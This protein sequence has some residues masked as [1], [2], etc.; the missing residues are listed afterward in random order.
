[1]LQFTLLDFSAGHPVFR[2]GGR[3]RIRGRL[4]E[5]HLWFALPSVFDTTIR[6]SGHDTGKCC[7]G[8]AVPND[9]GLVFF[10]RVR[11]HDARLCLRPA[12]KAFGVLLLQG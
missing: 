6:D 11:I 2:P 10:R 8:D 3:L 7:R 5:L 9:V 1:M 12:R 4:Q